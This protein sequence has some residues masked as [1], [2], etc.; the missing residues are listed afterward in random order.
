L[1]GAAEARWQVELLP[2]AQAGLTEI[3]AKY[4]DEA[5]D[6]AL[7]DILALEEDPT[8]QDAMAMRNTKDRR[9]ILHLPLP[10]PGH[11]PR[12]AREADR[13]RGTHRTERLG[14]P[15]GRLPEVSGLKYS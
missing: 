10:L 14:V 15:G 13:A 5:F 3:L 8:P 7:S 2:G 9:R 6:Q 4:G 12:A 11:L 1:S